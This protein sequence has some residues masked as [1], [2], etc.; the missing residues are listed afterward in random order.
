M[1]VLL[2]GLTVTSRFHSRSYWLRL[3]TDQATAMSIMIGPVQCG[4]HFRLR[5]HQPSICAIDK[6]QLLQD[7]ITKDKPLAR[8]LAIMRRS[9]TN[10]RRPFRFAH[11]QELST[12]EWFRGRKD[13]GRHLLTAA[14]G[15]TMTTL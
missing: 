8:I 1:L 9:D 4:G 10:S 6:H 3:E 15:F 14:N 2:R 5:S 12:I 11:S 7:S 13:G